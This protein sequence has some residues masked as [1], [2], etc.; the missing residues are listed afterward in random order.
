MQNAQES[1]LFC[2]LLVLVSVSA[3]VVQHQ[4]VLFHLLFLFAVNLCLS[5][6]LAVR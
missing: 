6:T 2:L 1:D 3:F 4:N 5:H